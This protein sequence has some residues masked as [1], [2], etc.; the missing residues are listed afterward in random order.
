MYSK[1]GRFG[2]PLTSEIIT[3]KL[4]EPKYLGRTAGVKLSGRMGLGQQIV[5]RAPGR[6]EDPGVSGS[7]SPTALVLSQTHI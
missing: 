7:P 3:A 4:I 5:W 2:A 1:R 6:R